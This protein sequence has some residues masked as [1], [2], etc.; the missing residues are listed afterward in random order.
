MKRSSF[1]EEQIIGIL[2]E[3][4][5]GMPTL[6]VSARRVRAVFEARFCFGAV[7]GMSALGAMRRKADVRRAEPEK[8]AIKSPT[9][10]TFELDSTTVKTCRPFSCHWRGEFWVDARTRCAGGRVQH[11]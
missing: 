4:Y 3:Q 6:E 2:K 9:F 5:A 1:S 7:S 8:G 10:P 11:G